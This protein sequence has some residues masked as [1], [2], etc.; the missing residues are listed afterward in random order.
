MQFKLQTCC[1]HSVSYL[2]FISKC[3]NQRVVVL[4]VYMSS[5]SPRMIK[6]Q[7]RTAT[8]HAFLYSVDWEICLANTR[9]TISLFALMYVWV[10]P[11]VSQQL[12]LI[13]CVGLW[14][15]FDVILQ[16]NSVILLYFDE[17]R[18]PVQLCMTY[19][20]ESLSDSYFLHI[21]CFV[22]KIEWGRLNQ[23]EIQA[24]KN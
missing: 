24:E 2:T 6:R 18:R 10:P 22:R 20:L 13:P 21:S 1:A 9:P 19:Y 12:L 23:E 16:L 11:N 4:W 8:S 3:F 5:E 17:R 7:A 15:V 14:A